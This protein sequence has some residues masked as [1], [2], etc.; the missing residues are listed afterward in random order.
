MITMRILAFLTE[1][2]QSKINLF[3][4]KVY[5]QNEHVALYDYRVQ[6]FNE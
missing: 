4:L 3:F 5:E 2:G 1:G 6:R